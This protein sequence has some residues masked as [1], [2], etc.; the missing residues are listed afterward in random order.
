MASAT[1]DLRLRSHPQNIT[2]PWPVPN[3]TTW[4]QRHMGVN[5]LPRVATQQC[6]GRES[7]L[8]LLAC[9]YLSNIDKA[10]RQPPVFIWH[11]TTLTHPTPC[12]V[13]S[14][15]C[16]SDLFHPCV[17]SRLSGQPGAVD[18]HWSHCGLFTLLCVVRY[19]KWINP[20]PVNNLTCIIPMQLQ[21][22]CG[23]PVRL[24]WLW[25]S[26]SSSVS[27]E[28][29]ITLSFLVQFALALFRNTVSNVVVCMCCRL[30]KWRN[31]WPRETD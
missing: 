4:W 27:F 20:T 3:Y 6:T 2:A 23:M 31:H 24:A 26:C 10:A 17:F 15:S 14:C 8:R 30:Q 7:N 29:R 16:S 1:P 19:W 11:N 28:S 9:T 18:L 22:D 5:N 12:H 25:W 21:Y 13:P